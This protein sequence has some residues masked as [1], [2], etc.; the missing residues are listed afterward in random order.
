MLAFFFHTADGI[1]VESLV[2]SLDCSTEPRTEQQQI[3]LFEKMF[4]ISSATSLQAF[5]SSA[6]F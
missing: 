6:V 4:V 1:N 3:I 2:L 5:L